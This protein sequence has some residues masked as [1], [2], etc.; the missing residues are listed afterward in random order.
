MHIGPPGQNGAPGLHGSPGSPGVPGQ[1]GDRGPQGLKG[2][3]GPIGQKGAQGPQ[4]PPGP[5][6]PKGSRGSTGSRGPT[7]PQGQKGATGLRGSKGQK[8]QAGFGGSKG[9]K[10]ERGLCPVSVNNCDC[11]FPCYAR[12]KRDTNNAVSE[13]D[14]P[15]VVY[16]HWGENSCRSENTNTVYSGTAV[17]GSSGNHL[18]LPLS[19]RSPTPYLM[20]SEIPCSVCLA[21]QY[22][23]VLMIP[24]EVTC[25]S[26][27]NSEYVGR[28]MTGSARSSTGQ[29]YCIDETYANSMMKPNGDKRAKDAF[30]RVKVDCN[31][32][33]AENCDSTLKCVVCSW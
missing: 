24:A 6:G 25:P 29:F 30:V 18:C 5:A 31:G 10:G 7:G 1:K 12:R 19:Q 4:G 16:T 23:T 27:W 14:V 33:L 3:S 20:H 26:G 22:S 11:P 15:G 21:L 17:S 8:G 9:Q 28:L 32:S 13:T 2:Q